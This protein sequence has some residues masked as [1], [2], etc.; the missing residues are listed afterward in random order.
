LI[1]TLWGRDIAELLAPGGPTRQPMDGFDSDYPDIVDY[2]LRC[3]HRIWEGKD[4]GLIETHYAPDCPIWLGAGPAA[5]V[6]G[7][8]AGTTRTLG[9]FP[10]RTL[11]GEA[12]IWS[13]EGPASYLSSH[14]I[15]SVATHHGH[16][17]FGPPTGRRVQFLTIADCLCRANEIV[18]EWLVRDN[19][20]IAVQL[21]LDP[22]ALGA[23]AAALDKADAPAPRWWAAEF[24]RVTAGA[25]TPFPDAPA[26]AADD[27]AFS[28]W[29]C[30]TVLNHRRLNMLRDAYAPNVRLWAPG[31]RLL[32]GHGEVIGWWTALLGCFGG[33][34]IS[35][36]HVGSVPASDDSADGTDTAVRW[37]LAGVHDGGGLYGPAS[38]RPVVIL[39]VTHRRVVAGRI[40]KEWTVFDEVAVW[41]QVAGAW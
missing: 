35:V 10:D 11:I 4:I 41:R 34:R 40:V 13:E 30:D 36:D 17:E 21:G 7:V 24:G 22:R 9:A 8:I 31:G 33:A 16:G 2:I 18:E 23:A 15:T 39:G 38:G 20:A 1:P 12:V 6:A 27:A 26:P 37:T 14:R 29:W 28:G 32:W 5:G 19:A 25:E 3:T